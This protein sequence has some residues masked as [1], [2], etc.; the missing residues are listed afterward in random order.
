MAKT[1]AERQRDYRRRKA[2]EREAARRAE[3]KR[4]LADI[5]SR[6]EEGFRELEAER[7]AAVRELERLRGELAKYARPC[8]AHQRSAEFIAR[9][10]NCGQGG[11]G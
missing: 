11:P 8:T 7:D 10:A 5:A 3:H 4:E 1:D 9:C 2:E 6:F